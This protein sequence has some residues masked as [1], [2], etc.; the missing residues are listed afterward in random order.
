MRAE[1]AFIGIPMVSSPAQFLENI[2]A[3][4]PS[5]GNESGGHRAASSAHLAKRFQAAGK[6]EWIAF[7]NLV[8]ARRE[9][10]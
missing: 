10:L 2:E 7:W 1:R 8:W 4:G 6:Y 3:Y 5:E 9:G